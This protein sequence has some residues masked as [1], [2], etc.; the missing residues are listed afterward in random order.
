MKPG[1]RQRRR[2]G[3]GDDDECKASAAG[4]GRGG[5]VVGC[6]PRPRALDGDAGRRRAGQF[7][8]MDRRPRPIRRGDLGGSGR[9]RLGHLRGDEQRRG[10]DLRCAGAGQPRCR[11]RTRRRRDPA[12]RRAP[13]PPG[14]D[15]SRGCR[16]LERQGPRHRDQARPIPRR[17]PH[18]RDAGVAAVGRRARRSRLARTG[19]RRSGHRAR[20][21]ARPPR[22][23][24]RE[25]GEHEHKGEH[26]GVAMAQ[27]SSLRYATFG[28]RASADRE[29]TPGSATAARRRWWRWPAARLVSAWR[30]VYAGNLRDIA[31]TESRDGGATFAAPARVSEDGWAINGCPDDGP[32]LAADPA[33][34]VHIV[35]ADGD[36]RRRAAGRALLRA[37]AA[38]GGFAAA[39]AHPDAGQPEALASAGGGG[40]HRPAV[41]RLGRIARRRAHRGVQRRR[42]L[43]PRSCASARRRDW[44]PTGRRSTR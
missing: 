6:A 28:D 14:G 9:R 1:T 3:S 35:V 38:T 8:T 10:R 7:G 19:A 29:I 23:G 43:A 31:F 2:R 42:S 11:R 25:K 21:V 34:G 16:G 37:D 44:R 33:G 40:R 30:H 41:R 5:G 18:L 24:G 32:A 12:A 22:P 17:R 4:G 27:M 20:D 39:R 26:D 13:R 15:A 36:P